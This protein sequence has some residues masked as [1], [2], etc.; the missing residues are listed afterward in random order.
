MSLTKRKTSAKRKAVEP[1]HDNPA[2]ASFHRQWQDIEK[3]QAKLAKQEQEGAGI[4]QRFV[5][6]IE[7]LERQQCA[8]I[9][10]LCQRLAGFTARK[11]FTQW[12]REMLHDWLNELMEYLESNPFRGELDLESL[13]MAVQSGSVTQLDEA[14]LEASCDFI[15]HMLQ[16][17]FGDSPDDIEVLREMVRHPEKLRDYM[18]AQAEM[19]RAGGAGAAEWDDEEPD[20]AEEA[21]ASD[22]SFERWQT[23]H[24]H[25][26]PDEVARVELLLD[27]STL[28][29][30]Y[31]K[32]AMALHPDREQDPAQR[33][34]KTRI[35]GELSLAWEQRDLFTL[36]QLAHSHLPEAENLLSEENLAAINPALKLKICE[37]KV[38][39]YGGTEG[40]QG[41]VLHK[42]K[43]SSKKKTDLAFE[44]HQHYLQRDIKQLHTQLATITTLQTLKPYLAKRWDEREYA[45]WDEAAGFDEIFFR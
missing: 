11:S 28:K 13:Y 26:H 45:A 33:D 29:Q 9:F 23:R 43:Q 24:D 3:L 15:T 38:R 20:F 16:E 35:M 36:L 14:Q 7:P 41:A 25:V 37:L 2:L 10:Q 6:D 34:A 22:E 21:F 40:V 19:R 27:S 1:R 39:Y 12:Q 30:L 44:D 17:A 32:L 42:F 8:L 4:Y 31:R 5:S 18:K